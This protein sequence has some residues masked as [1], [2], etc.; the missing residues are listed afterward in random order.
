M[1]DEELYG[2]LRAAAQT[3]RLAR[4]ETARHLADDVRDETPDWLLERLDG[5]L[6]AMDAAAGEVGRF[7]R[8]DRSGVVPGAA[9][10]YGDE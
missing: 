7:I 1:T 9:I 10:D 3:L 4:Q 5:A 2:E 6:R 8:E